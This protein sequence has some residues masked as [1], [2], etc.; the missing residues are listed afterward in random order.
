[1][2]GTGIGDRGNHRLLDAAR[3]VDEQI[4]LLSREAGLRLGLGF[5]KLR[6]DKPAFFEPA[7]AVSPFENLLAVYQ[8]RVDGLQ[9]TPIFRALTE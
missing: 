1:M 9:F 7:F 3:G 5:R 2:I 6:V 4:D 8:S